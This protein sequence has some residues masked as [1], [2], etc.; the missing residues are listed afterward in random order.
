MKKVLITAGPTFEA[1][2]PVR[3]IGNW[4]SGL[5]GISL[6]DT[7][8]EHNYDVTL[9]CGKTHIQNQSKN[10]KRINIISAQEMY[11][12]VMKH[13]DYDIAI[14]AAAVADYRPK[15]V[16]KQKIKKTQ[17]R[18][19]IDLV[20]NPDILAS[21]G[22]IKKENQI[23]VG[24]ALETE[25]ALENA[26]KKLISKNLDYIVINSLE[27]EGAGFEKKTN[28]ISILSSFGT[29]LDYPLMSKQEVAEKIRLCIAT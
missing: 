23:L 5:M 28:K 13:T 12:E 10:L 15:E 2:D 27:D 16:S 22:K 26:N 17:E 25:N 4:S 9:V 14:L 1:I 11:D 3:F 21:L 7:F 6:A 24:F 20:K 18:I 19:S 8:A 29:V